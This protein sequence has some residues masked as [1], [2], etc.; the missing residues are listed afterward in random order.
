MSEDEARYFLNGE[1]AVDQE[2]F[3][4]DSWQNIKPY[5]MM[6]SG[7]FKPPG[8]GEAVEEEIDEEQEADDHQEGKKLYNFLS[9]SVRLSN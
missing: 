3:V 5:L 8:E 7:L 6:D 2:K 1:D 9:T 4:T